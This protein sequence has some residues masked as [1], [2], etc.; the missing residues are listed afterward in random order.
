M[1]REKVEM[2][3]SVCSL[4]FTLL[5]N[6][7]VFGLGNGLRHAISNK[8]QGAGAWCDPLVVSPLIELEF[9]GKKN[10]SD[11]TYCLHGESFPVFP[12][13][14]NF[15]FHKVSIILVAVIM[16][17]SGLSMAASTVCVPVLF[18]FCGGVWRWFWVFSGWSEFRCLRSV[19]C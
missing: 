1:S 18:D 6:N 12:M 17:P 7:N 3:T 11:V 8:R 19:G 14:K 5:F 10:V 16:L 9:R 13:S 4:A 15:S 2:N